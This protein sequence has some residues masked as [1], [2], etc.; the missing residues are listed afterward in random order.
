MFAVAA[1]GCGDDD[2]PPGKTLDDFLPPLPSPTGEAQAVWAGRITADKASEL[3]DGPARSGLVG[4]YYMRNGKA[5]FVIQN[6]QRAIGVVPWGGNVVDAVPV[7]ADGGDLAEDHLGEISMV[8]VLGRTCAHDRIEVLLDGSGGGPAV[9]RA[10][11]VGRPN[12]YV[13]LR[14]IGLLPIPAELDPDIEDG[15]ACATTYTLWPQSPVLEIAW[16]LFNG[17]QYAVEGPFGTINDTGGTVESFSPGTI[18]FNRMGIDALTTAADPQP[19]AYAV[20]QGPGVGY[21]I[22]PVHADPTTPNA[23]FLVA[24]VSVIIFGADQLFD[25]LNEESNPFYLELPPQ[26][27]VTHRLDLVAAVDGADVEEHYR[28]LLQQPVGDVSGQ[29]AFAPGG[30]AGAGARVG[31]FVD[32][33]GNGALDDDDHVASYMDCDATGAFSGR[34]PHGAYLARADVKDVARSPVVSFTVGESPATVVGLDLPQPARFDYTI[35]DD[36]TGAPVPAKLTV[37]GRTSVPLDKRVMENYDR[38]GGIVVTL[39]AVH[40]TSVPA[41]PTDP[42]DPQLVL[43]AGGPYRIFATHGTEWSF[44]SVVVSPTAGQTGTL[45]FRIRRVLDTTGYVATEFHQHAVGSPDSPVPFDL[46]LKSLVT[47][48]IEFFASTDHDYLSDYDPWIDLF[49]VRGWVDGVVGIE[50]TP[51]AYGHFIAFPLEI[52]ANDPTNGAV[53]WATGPLPGFAMLP[54]ELWGALRQRGARVVQVN[55]PRALSSLAGFQSY[56]DRAGLT[57]D[58]AAHQFYGDVAEQPVP[59]D[60]LRLPDGTKVFSDQFDTLEVWNG[61][62]TNDTDFDGVREIT[63]LDLV[64]RD[65]F[66]F[67]SFGKL[68]TPIGNSDTHTAE[69]D[70]AGLPRTLVRVPDDSFAAIMTGLEEDVYATLLGDGAPRDVVVT[71]GPMLAVSADGG[72]TSAIGATVSPGAGGKVTLTIKASSAEWVQFDTIEVFANNSYERV[73]RNKTALQPIACFTSRPA[74]SI[75]ADKDPCALAPL[76]GARVMSVES[77]SVGGGYRV[78]EATVTLELTA[79]DVAK[80]PEAT[81]DDAWLVVRVRGQRPVYPVLIEGAVDDS[82]VDV[83]VSGTEAQIDAALAGKG[84]P[85]TAFTAPILVDFDGGGWKAPLGP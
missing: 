18:G 21:G 24:G 23:T 13:N 17:G 32:T 46:R 36:D 79:A 5:R 25:I 72:A 6:E 47:E 35:V 83:L 8:Y 20:Y 39:H 77:R 3:I 76:G 71:N 65:W 19:A 63:S 45:Q 74:S 4:D 84:V 80:R 73:D 62:R 2:P 38:R 67:L 37:I 75:V 34:L 12:D 54:G 53:D 49:G 82:N 33:N 7:G 48:G 43:P 44:D 52:D 69:K 31:V 16:T 58:F 22:V 64:M 26:D 56:F 78:W 40:G 51:F 14:G 55:H 61:F 60:W 15:V 42:A 9:V 27:G 68:V 70:P 30:A 50:A 85:A 41:A 29:V 1:V 66:N 59:A 81:G 28:K 11:G 57:F 10:Y